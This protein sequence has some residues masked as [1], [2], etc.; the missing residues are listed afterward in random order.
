MIL[1]HFAAFLLFLL[2]RS[3]SLLDLAVVVPTAPGDTIRR[4]SIRDSW[5]WQLKQYEGADSK[6]AIKLHF[7]I[8]DSA[9]LNSDQKATLEEERKQYD[10]IRELNGFHDRYEKM[11]QKVL[12]IFKVCPD[13]FG[14]YRLLLKA[15]PDS[16]LHVARLIAVLEE[17]KAFDLPW[18]HAGVF[19]RNMPIMQ[20]SLK[21]STGLDVYPWNARGAALI[22]SRDLV[23]FM[24]NSPVPFKQ[25]KADDAMIG[26]ILAPYEYN[27]IDLDISASWPQCG[28]AISCAY[29]IDGTAKETY[30]VDHY[31]TLET[32]RWKQRRYEMFGDSCWRMG[33]P[34]ESSCRRATLP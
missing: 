4:C 8:G 31:N 6:R 2:R 5:M 30:Q 10:D 34:Q 26:T 15:D 22:L 21:E 23:E 33:S 25:M 28:C 19:W 18:V 1:L 14:E 3:L 24:G 16:Y 20:E 29:D 32:L 27:R 9:E 12:E 7:I 17:K 11:G 13:I